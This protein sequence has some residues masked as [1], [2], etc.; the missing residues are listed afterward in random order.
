M[1]STA[2]G[3]A[4]L[5]SVTA[6]AAV[7]VVLFLS[8]CATKPTLQPGSRGTAVVSLQQRLAQLG[9]DVGTADG[10]FGDA[11][12]HAV[13]AFQKVN[14]LNRDGVVR[15]DTWAALDRPS[16][17]RARY[18]PVVG[19]RHVTGL[20]IDL[21]RQVLYLTYQGAVT[22]IID[23]STGD[24]SRGP[25]YSYTPPGNYAIYRINSVGWEY[26]PLGGLYKPAYFHGGYAVHGATSVPPYPASH[27][28]VRTTVAARD[29]L[30]PWLWVGMP[31]AVYSK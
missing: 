11:T 1:P 28:C 20:E 6:A 21:S 31:V 26:G 10:M 18:N 24:G 7:L 5:R 13:V 27:G 22:R 12:R 17:P 15:A 9:Y 8:G 3:S 16:I 2:S 19:G 4:A 23:A 25:P 29:R 14:S 30:Q